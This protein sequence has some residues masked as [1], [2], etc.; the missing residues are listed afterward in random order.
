MYKP[1]K[2]LHSLF[3]KHFNELLSVFC[4]LELVSDITPGKQ[5]TNKTTTCNQDS[6]ISSGMIGSVDLWNVAHINVSDG[7]Y[8]VAIWS[9]DDNKN[10]LMMDST[11]SFQIYLLPICLYS[12][13]LVGLSPKTRNHKWLLRMIH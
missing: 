5:E 3:W 10:E 7:T 6:F 11:L 8:L 4:Q 2:L 12:V 9:C 1:S 13:M